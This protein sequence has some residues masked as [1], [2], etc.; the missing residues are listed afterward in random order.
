L[1]YINTLNVDYIIGI[2][3]VEGMHLGQVGGGG[4]SPISD[5]YTK[6]IGSITKS[7]TMS[8]QVNNTYIDFIFNC[9]NIVSI[10]VSIR[11]TNYD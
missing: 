3:E 9:I 5:Y 6:N 10:N 1:A 11:N 7:I 8:I 4:T 2:K